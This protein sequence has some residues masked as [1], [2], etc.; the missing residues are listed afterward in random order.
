MAFGDPGGTKCA[1]TWTAFTTGVMALSESFFAASCSWRSEGLFGQSFSV[2]L[3]I[4]ALRGIPCL[5]SFSVVW[6]VRH[7]EG[8][9]WLGSYSLVQC[10]RHSVGQ[11]IA[12]PPMRERGYDDGS[13]PLCMIQQYLLA[14]KSAQL[15]STGI[16]PHDLLPHIPSIHLYSLSSSPHPGIAPQSLNSSSQLLYLPGD[17]CPCLRYVWLQQGLSA[18]HSI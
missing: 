7:I 13:T 18:S 12:Q 4:Q 14:S 8:P 1:E 9:P 15:S 3:P 11:S 17:L 6:H 10:V 5:G 2:A 16:S